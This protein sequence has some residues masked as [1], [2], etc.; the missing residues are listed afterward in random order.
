MKKERFKIAALAVLLFLISVP[1]FSLTSMLKGDLGDS[2]KLVQDVMAKYFS[3]AT[4]AEARGALEALGPDRK[5]KLANFLG[6]TGKAA[7]L[8]KCQGE[9][10]SVIGELKPAGQI[11]E[12]DFQKAFPEIIGIANNSLPLD[13][14]QKFIAADADNIGPEAILM[15]WQG[16][17]KFWQIVQDQSRQE[18]ILN[19]TPDW[20]L[21]EIGLKR[22]AEVKDYSS[23]AYK[24]EWLKGKSKVQGEEKILFNNRQNPR[25]IYMKWLDGPWKGRE[26]VYNEVLN[27]DK[28]RVRE[29]GL[30]GKAGALWLDYT[31][32]LARRGTNHTVPE[33]GLKFFMDILQKDWKH[34]Q[35]TN[36]LKRVNK[37]IQL[38]D[39]R[40]V[41]V[42][43]ITLPKDPKAGYYCYR[44]IQYIDYE[45]AFE[46]KIENYDWNN[47]F[48]ESYYYTEIKF[49]PG[50]PDNTYDP[51]NPEY[52]L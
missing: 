10:C 24:Q 28:I 14:F 6:E 43:E 35:G 46:P 7:V 23:I 4:A 22:L 37:G 41:Y 11:S 50:L 29:G 5:A 20:A 33:M 40:K 18:T 2:H 47:Q 34:A 44:S 48:L 12:A 3:I 52:N 51:K 31:G 39:G 25:G 13:K 36:D 49:N 16:Q 9:G 32:D 1:A 15:G 38:L 26:L 42:M 17:Q 8:A 45:A 21:L 30:L 19:A 27:K